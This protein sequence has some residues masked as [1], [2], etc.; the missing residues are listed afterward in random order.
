MYQKSTTIA[1]SI[2]N[3]IVHFIKYLNSKHVYKMWCISQNTFKIPIAFCAK[4]IVK[5][6]FKFY[7]SRCKI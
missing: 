2:D 1:R 3:S 5:H 7:L 6:S 4:S